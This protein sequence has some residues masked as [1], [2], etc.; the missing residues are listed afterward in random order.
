MSM[1]RNR[2]YC[3]FLSEVKIVD[4]LGGTISCSRPVVDNGWLPHHCQ[5]GTSGKTVSPTV[6]LAL[7]ISGQGNHV[8]GMDTSRIIIAVNKDPAAPIFK[9]AHYGVVDDLLQLVPEVIKQAQAEI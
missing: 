5:V 9:V 7:G 2:V 6:Y 1:R 4:K 3:I 8:A